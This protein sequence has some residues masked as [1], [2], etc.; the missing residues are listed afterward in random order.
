MKLVALRRGILCER[1]LIPKCFVYS[2]VTD[3]HMKA[4]SDAE[5]AADVAEMFLSFRST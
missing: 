5:T 2:A 1:N 3:L 4:V